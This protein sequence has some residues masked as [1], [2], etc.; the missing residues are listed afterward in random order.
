VHKE[1][2]MQLKVNGIRLQR[3]QEALVQTEKVIKRL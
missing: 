3:V 1:L 2:F